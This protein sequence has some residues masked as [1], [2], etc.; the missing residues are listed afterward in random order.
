MK[1]SL[2]RLGERLREARQRRAVT[3]PEMARL[4]GKSKQLVSAWEQGRSEILVS[5]LATVAQI[6]S[7]DVNWLVLGM[8]NSV[9]ASTGF[10]TLPEGML[11]PVLHPHEVIKHTD[12][13]LALE[14]VESKAYTYFQTPPGSLAFEMPDTSMLGIVSKGELV[15]IGP[16]ECIDPGEIVAAVVYA[17][18][19][20]ELEAPMLALREIRFLSTH[21]GKAP[22]ELVASGRGY[23]KITSRRLNMPS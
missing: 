22:F 9:V 21:I 19:D 1:Y 5:T 17:D 18:N 3:Q 15:V 16:E 4:L 23:S 2:D 12:G 6:L 20:V 13:G 11:V 14:N 8:K 10:P 7:V